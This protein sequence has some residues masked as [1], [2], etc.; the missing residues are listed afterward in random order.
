MKSS[1]L[2]YSIAYCSSEDPRFPITSIQSATI[3]SSGWQSDANPLYPVYFVVDLGAKCSL[4]ALQFVSHQSKIAQRVDLSFSDTEDTWRVLGSFQ[5]SDNSH[6]RYS[7]REL[8]SASLQRVSARYIKVSITNC[9]SNMNNPSNQVGIV[10]LR[11]MGRGEQPAQIESARPISARPTTATAAADLDSRIANLEMKKKRAVENEE[12]LEA[13]AIKKELDNLKIKRDTLLQLEKA[14]KDAIEMEDFEAASQFKA[15]IDRILSGS[16]D[17]PM[18]Q[19]T[20]PPSPPPQQSVIEERPPLRKGGKLEKSRQIFSSE[21]DVDEYAVPVIHSSNGADLSDER[22]IRPRANLSDDEDDDAETPSPA[23]AIDLGGTLKSNQ[24]LED[25]VPESD[26]APDELKPADRQEAAT[27]IAIA[28]EDAVKRFFSKNWILKVQGIKTL[29]NKITGLASGYDKAFQNFCYILRH[30]LQDTQKQIVVAALNGV[31]DIAETH[32]I[33]SSELTRCV[34]NLMT[35]IVPKI[36]GAQQAISDAVCDFLVWLSQKNATDLVLPVI[37]TPAKNQAQWKITKAKIDT[38][39]NMVLLHGID[40]EPGLGVDEVMEFLL[41]SLES[42][43]S[44]VR[45]AAIELVVTLEVMADGSTSKYTSE[46]P[47]RI[48][49]EIRKMIENAENGIAE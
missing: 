36:G 11:I 28:G 10:S 44:E 24:P 9:Y 43:K 25:D 2:D 3:R 32:Q 35:H 17:A 20:P 21:M 39:H 4:D 14:K 18:P 5:F 26:E 1:F 42:A 40:T 23:F 45:S 48:Q 47:T 16:D 30:R 15:R 6:T 31:R 8:K 37:M 22:P 33:E 41:P 38:L 12:F 46:L 13:G 34:S 29:V 49:R 7:A 19:R 27:L